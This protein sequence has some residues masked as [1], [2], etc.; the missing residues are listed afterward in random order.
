MQIRIFAFNAFKL[1]FSLSRNPLHS[2]FS[3]SV[4]NYK[5]K[6]KKKEGNGTT[7]VI[8]ILVKLGNINFWL[9]RESSEI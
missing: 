6:Q 1:E 2:Q 8:S 4:L 9:A 5:T 7:K 3:I